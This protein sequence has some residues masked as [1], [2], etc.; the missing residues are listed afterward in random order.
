[1]R[2]L[3]FSLFCVVANG[4]AMF[5]SYTLVRIDPSNGSVSLRWE[6]DSRDFAQFP[7][8]ASDSEV[9][10]FGTAGTA[11]YALE[12][13]TDIQFGGSV[14]KVDWSMSPFTG[15]PYV[16]GLIF[17]DIHTDDGTIPISASITATLRP[18]VTLPFIGGYNDGY[19]HVQFL[20]FTPDTAQATAV[21]EPSAVWLWALCVAGLTAK[22]IFG[23]SYRFSAVA[24]SSN[25]HP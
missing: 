12:N 13:Q 14:I 19:A 24:A 16:A 15:F 7:L 4:S 8:S 2:F 22:M 20:S 3:L 21:P 6:L 11:R 18:H 23:K 1:M 17:T 10:D 25:K 9:I 5:P